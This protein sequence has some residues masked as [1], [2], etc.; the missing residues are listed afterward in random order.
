[1]IE[2]LPSKCETLSS[3][4]STARKV[5]FF[6]CFLAGSGFEVSFVLARQVLMPPALFA[7]VILEIGVFLFAPA[8]LEGDP[9]I[10]SFP[11]LLG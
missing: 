9:P 3:S 8:T 5:N 7:L 4:S 2:C 1:M 10:L 11:L 6:V